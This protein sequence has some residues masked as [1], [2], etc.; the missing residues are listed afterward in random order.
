V[1]KNA[2]A[3]QIIQVCA[4][5]ISRLRFPIGRAVARPLDEPVREFG[6]EDP[7][8]TNQGEEKSNADGELKAEDDA[9]HPWH[10]GANCALHLG[11]IDS[12]PTSCWRLGTVSGVVSP[13]PVARGQHIVETGLPGDFASRVAIEHTRRNK[14]AD[15]SPF[16]P[17]SA[18]EIRTG[19]R[20]FTA[21]KEDDQ[22]RC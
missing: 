4:G 20:Y 6:A 22:P 17:T 14:P 7:D 9:V 15:S 10:Q 18:R 5:R 21:M 16:R 8:C 1:A 12:I 3:T 19:S 11:H 2:T 13:H